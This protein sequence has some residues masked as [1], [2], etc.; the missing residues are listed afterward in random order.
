MGVKYN[1]SL[2]WENENVKKFKLYIYSL[3]EKEEM[4][5]YLLR[6]LGSCLHG[7]NQD[8][9]I[10]FMFGEGQN[11]KSLLFTILRKI[12]GQYC[13][14]SSIK[15]LTNNRSK[16][17]DASPEVARLK[18][19]RLVLLDEADNHEK[20]Q[21]SIMKKF[22]GNDS[23]TARGLYEKETEFSPQFKM[24]VSMNSCPQLDNA[25]YGTMRRLCKID[26]NT[27]FIDPNTKRLEDFEP[28]E[29]PRI[30]NI[31]K[32]M[33]STEMLEAGL[34]VLFEYY[35][36]Y[37]QKGGYK[38]PKD[39]QLSTQA[40]KIE[41]NIY[42]QFLKNN[43]TENTT[44][45]TSENNSEGITLTEIYNKYKKYCE[46]NNIFN[47]ISKNEFLSQLTLLSN[48][49][50]ILRFTIIKTNKTA[51]IKGLIEIPS[52]YSDSEYNKSINT[53]NTSTTKSI[54]ELKELK[55]DNKSV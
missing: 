13:I 27:K 44:G 10:F 8:N 42:L 5:E 43:Y 40:Y 32:I 34:W 36:I 6:V 1:S 23:I 19:V 49:K 16:S 7:Y 18:N 9:K 24:I 48:N 41:G 15:I 35:K 4:A 29:K 11:G 28:N 51:I 26:F 39:V 14:T 2:T 45:N 21:T 30:N 22:T 20:I 53:T 17:S 46:D 31:E 12:F 47:K 37:M 38:E 3:Q 55:E 33:T 25:D 50:D 52:D 54:E